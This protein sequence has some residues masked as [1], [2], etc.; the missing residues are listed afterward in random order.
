MPF[1]TGEGRTDTEQRASDLSPRPTTSHPSKDDEDA[2][3]GAAC[4]FRSG[5]GGVFRP[6]RSTR[7]AT[8]I[9]VT[10]IARLPS[11]TSESVDRRFDAR[12]EAFNTDPQCVTTTC[13]QVGFSDPWSHPNL[14]H[15]FMKQIQLN[16]EAK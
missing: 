5:E 12:I 6:S 14:K 9:A 13:S 11:S 4:R 16:K 15:Q 8:N 1:I 3:S 7:S 2:R 10:R